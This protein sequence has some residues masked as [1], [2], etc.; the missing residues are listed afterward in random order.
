MPSG[1]WRVDLSDGRVPRTHSLLVSSWALSTGERNMLDVLDDNL[2]TWTNVGT[3][4]VL[5]Q[6]KKYYLKQWK[7]ETGLK[8][9]KLNFHQYFTLKLFKIVLK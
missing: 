1:M 6:Q 9:I 7:P 3:V 4:G 2:P 8:P 5:K